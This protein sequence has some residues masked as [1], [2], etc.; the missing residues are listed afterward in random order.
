[1]ED[2]NK[3]EEKAANE[4]DINERAQETRTITT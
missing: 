1:M 2:K 4:K 3:K